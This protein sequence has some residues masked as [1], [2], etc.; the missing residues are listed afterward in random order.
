MSGLKRKQFVW[1]R[2]LPLIKSSKVSVQ[3][4]LLLFFLATSSIILCVTDVSYYIVDSI[5]QKTLGVIAPVMYYLNQPFVYCQK[6]ITLINKM[7]QD[8][9]QYQSLENL[10]VE[11][12]SW[13]MKAQI[14]KRENEQLRAILKTVPQKSFDFI[15]AK[16]LGAPCGREFSTLVVDLKKDNIISENSPVMGAKGLVGRIV[17][18]GQNVIQITLMTDLH[19]RTPVRFSMNGEQAILAGTGTGE[20]EITH[21]RQVMHNAEVAQLPE[22]HCVA[23][24]DLLLT[25]GFGGVYPPDIP[26]AIVSR[27]VEHEG[28]VKVYAKPVEDMLT[29]EFVRIL[30]KSYEANNTTS[31]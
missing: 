14:L 3:R 12:N 13:K 23:V 10:A 15:T 25:S 8:K 6:Q 24:G 21:R 26:V 17:V 16:V 22:N 4:L 31:S 19:A 9:D 5:H 11:L 27:L 30:D 28:Q 7:V 20:L 1:H 18:A 2:I 29:L